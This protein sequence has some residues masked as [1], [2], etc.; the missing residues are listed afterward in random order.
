MIVP[1][2]AAAS[3]TGIALLV[4][5][6]LVI[7]FILFVTFISRYKKCPPDL[8]EAMESGRIKPE[9]LTE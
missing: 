2:F 8:K 7:L 6:L 4:A 3:L 9:D 5:V 1:I